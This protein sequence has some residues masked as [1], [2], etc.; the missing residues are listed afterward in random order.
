M[1]PN[2]P[3]IDED[4][5]DNVQDG[6]P[7]RSYHWLDIDRNA[8]GVYAYFKNGKLYQ[9]SVHTPRFALANGVHIDSRTEEVKQAYP[10]GREY[11]LLGS[12]SAVVGGKDLIYWVD[13]ADGI[14]FEFYWNGRKHERLVS[15]ID[16]FPKGSDYLP[17]GCISPPQ[18]WQQLKQTPR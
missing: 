16:I 14:A 1:F 2:H 13:M 12:G 4:A 3:G 7:G 17:S 10:G 15:G 18:K 11:M 5:T 8:N 6:C 9:L